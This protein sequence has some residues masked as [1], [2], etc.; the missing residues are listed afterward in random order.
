MDLPI[1]NTCYKWNHIIR[2]QGSI[3]ALHYLLLPNDVSFNGQTTCYL[4]ISWWIFRLFSLFGYYVAMNI[5]VQIFAG[6]KNY[7]ILN[8][9]LLH[10]KIYAKCVFTLKNLDIKIFFNVVRNTTQ[11][12]DIQFSFYNIIC[13]YL[14]YL[15]RVSRT[16]S[17]QK[18]SLQN[19]I[20]LTTYT[21]AQPFY[22]GCICSVLLPV[23]HK[24]EDVPWQYSWSVKVTPPLVLIALIIH[25][26]SL[27]VSFF[28]LK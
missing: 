7:L 15:W 24:I 14:I 16:L 23:S 4:L 27:L 13:M 21:V 10:I 9:V 20:G 12:I 19:E 28:P 3:S 22:G 17:L 2:G 5:H 1:V 25:L 18:I 8:I 6:H 11:V 26:L